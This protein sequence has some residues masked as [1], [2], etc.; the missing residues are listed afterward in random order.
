MI[1]SNQVDHWTSGTVFECNEVAGSPD[2]TEQNYKIL[3]KP[4]CKPTYDETVLLRGL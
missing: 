4:L 2:Y 1:G 3:Q